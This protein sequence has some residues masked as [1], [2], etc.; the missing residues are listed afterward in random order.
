MSKS[1][2]IPVIS[3]GLCLI[4]LTFHIYG[5]K[6]SYFVSTAANGLCMII[7]RCTIAYQCRYNGAS[8]SKEIIILWVVMILTLTQAHG[9]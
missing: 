2:L 4:M 1:F 9:S 8:L 7:C 3:D 6:G 5:I